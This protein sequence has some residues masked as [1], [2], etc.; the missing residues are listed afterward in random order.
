MHD[1]TVE[2]VDPSKEYVPVD[3]D[4]SKKKVAIL[5][6]KM[7]SRP[8][9]DK[10]DMMAEIKALSAKVKQERSGERKRKW[11][12]M[13][14]RFNLLP[15]EYRDMYVQ[16]RDHYQARAD[17]LLKA[18]TGRINAT[19]ADA[20][21]KK[22]VIDRLRIEFESRRLDGPYFP[23]A[24]FGDYWLHVKDYKGAPLFEMYET[25]NA[26]RTREKELRKEG[27][28]P[29]VGTKLEN[30]PGQAGANAGFMSDIA[31][32]LDKIGGAKA[33]QVKDDIY[34]L[35]LKT[36]PDLSARKSFIHRKKTKGYSQ[37][38][39]RAFAHKTFHIGSQLARL[40]NSHQLERLMSEMGDEVKKSSD[41]VKSGALLNEMQKRHQWVM[42]PGDSKIANALTGMGFIWYLGVSPAAAAVN[43]TQNAVTAFPVLSSKF[44]FARSALNMA[45]AI[46]AAFNSQMTSDERKMI[47]QLEKDGVIDTTNAHDLAGIASSDTSGYNENW[48]RTMEVA[49]WAFHHAEVFNRVTTSMAAYRMARADGKSHDEAVELARAITWESHF[50]YSNTNRPRFMQANWQ[51]VVFLFKQYSVNMTYY[52]ARNAYKVL[53]AETPAARREAATKLFGTLAVTSGIAGAAGLPLYSVIAFVAN[54]IMSTFGDD[55]EPYDFEDEMYRWLKGQF[56]ADWAKIIL[57]GPANEL[58]A[59][60]AS[61]TKLDEM[62]VRSPDRELEG[63]AMTQHYIEQLLGPVF[64]VGI[65]A[66]AGAQLMGEGHYRRGIEKMVPKVARDLLTSL[67]FAQEG[68]RTMRGDP[69][70]PEFDPW[71]IALKA[72]G[73]TPTKLADRYDEDNR[74]R[75]VESRLK[76]R[77]EQLMD[78]YW[79]AYQAR[80][81]EGKSDARAAIREWNTKHRSAAISGTDLQAS[82]RS[83]RS[84]TKQAAKGVVIGKD[85][86][87]EAEEFR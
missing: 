22:S 6:E 50:D 59:D 12:E 15:K 77:R 11:Q 60:L 78:A 4:E 44:G 18:L 9:D 37:D 2:G 70:V 76:K 14:S 49:S 21:V 87:K 53:K 61:R 36:L 58:G 65:N 66:I 30:P 13:R 19:D 38:A 35:Y 52:L 41:S 75:N 27:F 62:W 39:I 68:A 55:D 23:L 84:Y 48:R 40:E 73:F 26:L 80:D 1:T 25:V 67:R 29:K 85:Y 69:M 7:F 16:V 33:E 45:K 57:R 86:R 79:L 83:R 3:I 47:E 54:A 74:L 56:G 31:S 32:M 72:T 17:E 28:D 10:T 64:G 63:K 8:G 51:K 34:Q 20:G 81:A 46:P 82:V 5:R 42:N 43:L 71:E 24:R